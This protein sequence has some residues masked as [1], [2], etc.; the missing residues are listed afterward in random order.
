MYKNIVAIPTSDNHIIAY[1]PKYE[2]I[3]GD[4]GEDEEYGWLCKLISKA[5]NPLDG[6]VA[7]FPYDH[8]AKKIKIRN[9]SPNSII[10][11]EELPFNQEDCDSGFIFLD[12]ESDNINISLNGDTLTIA[13]TDDFG[14]SSSVSVSYKKFLSSI[15]DAGKATLFD[16]EHDYYQGER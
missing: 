9:S 4:W 10:V 12:T 8:I 13:Y 2:F 1:M 16:M 14:N 15:E 6:W 5:E 11:T 3:S 7:Y